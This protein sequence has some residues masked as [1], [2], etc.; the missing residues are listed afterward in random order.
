MQCKVLSVYYSEQ[1]SPWM[2]AQWV[3]IIE[4]QIHFVAGAVHC[5]PALV[6]LSNDIL[7][8]RF[9]SIP[10]SFQYHAHC[11]ILNMQYRLLNSGL[12]NAINF[13]TK[14]HFKISYTIPSSIN[15]EAR[16]Q[17][18]GSREQ[19]I[20]KNPIKKTRK[21]ITD[22]PLLLWNKISFFY[23]MRFS[24]SL[25][26]I[27]VGKI[28]KTLIKKNISVPTTTTKKHFFLG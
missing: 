26:E 15:T 16:M 18:T 7:P 24:V 19:K 28:R 27:F 12:L 2:A 21:N 22:D 6:R 10:I 1:Y 17:C 8:Y 13:V 25:C 14:F 11:K 9:N 5:I 23:L 20:K 3:E 4:L